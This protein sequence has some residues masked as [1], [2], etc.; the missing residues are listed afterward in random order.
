VTNIGRWAVREVRLRVSI[1]IDLGT[2]R[3]KLLALDEDGSVLGVTMAS[4][5]TE[6]RRAGYAEQNPERWWD[7]VRLAM[8]ELLSRPAL[9][10]Q[11]VEA[12]GLTGQMHGA[13]F[14][15]GLGAPVRPALIW[16]DGRAESETAEIEAR[17]PREELVARTGNRSNV[18]F[19]APKIMW[20]ARN[21]PETF[22]RTRWVVQ[23][24]DALRF[25]LTGEVAG[26][27][28]DAS[29][30]LLFDLRARA[31]AADLCARLD[32]D[33]TRLPPLSESEARAGEL[34]GEAARALG[35]PAGITV[36]VGGA[37]APAAALGLGLGREADAHGAVLISLGTGGQVLAPTAE[38]RIDP[39]G[40]LHGLC[41]VV[42]GQWCVMAAIL[43]AAAA[44]DWIVRLLRPDD[45]NAVRELLAAATKVPAGSDGLLFLPYLRGERTPHFD[46]AARGAMVGLRISHGP[47]EMTRAVLE[48]VALALAEGMD[49]MKGVGV[50]P[51]SG[52]VAGGG[53]NRLWQ[54]IIADVLDMPVALGAT[55]HGS[56]RGAALLGAVAAGILPSTSQGTPPLPADT[57]V[58]EPDPAHRQ[59]YADLSATYREL[60]SRLP[61]R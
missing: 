48:G 5:A 8:S 24:K 56:A 25:R 50:Q 26:D 31:W 20:V 12:L 4:Y 23:P 42:P 28:S 57:R 55:E 13:V 46:P 58:M 60:Y 9:R 38:P 17:I 32:I 16:S 14:L 45:P 6:S 29:A 34:R 52:V 36:A 22:A 11:S 49:L 40:R 15:D 53:V 10:G 41:H 39:A 33:A 47:P 2:T 18:S 59:V 30:T 19:T 51:T 37:D 61:R 44:L 21:E 1:G 43:S 27:V 54:Q 7:A 35:L 3:V